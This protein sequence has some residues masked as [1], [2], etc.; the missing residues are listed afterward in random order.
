MSSR[1]ASSP[2]DGIRNPP[3]SPA[4]LKIG[5]VAG[6]SS[7]DL[8]GAGLIRSLRTL[9]PDAEFAGMAG[10]RMKAEG[11]V[12]WANYDRLAVMGFGEVLG[13]L[14]ELIRLRR[15]LRDRFGDWQPDV[16]VG[17]DSPD[18]NLGL[19]IML[20]GTGIPTVH[21]V[22]PS[23]WA[24]RPRRVKKIG[25]A[26]N[27]VLCL[28]PFETAPYEAAGI[29]VRF[30][31]HPLA[32]HFPPK[33]D[34]SAARLDLGLEEYHQ[35][36]ALMPGSRATELRALTDDFLLA[37][38]WLA[39][40]RRELIFL[41]PMANPDLAELFETRLREL[42]VD[43]DIRVI[44]GRSHDA[45]AAANVVLL[46]SGTATLEAAL[47]KRPMVVAYRVSQVSRFILKTFRLLKVNQFALP[48]LLAG[49]NLVPEIMQDDITPE[50]LGHAV[51]EFLDNPLL[52]ERLVESFDEI[53]AGLRQQADHQAAEAVFELLA[54]GDR[55]KRS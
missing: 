52:G 2:L 35:V 22:S 30:V 49:E 41:A 6:E 14:G 25:R 19:E 34:R 38:D 32:D 37:A 44:A 23:L 28:L 8:L 1:A 13:R 36:V 45:I 43:A 31:G 7:G 55:E 47:I 21:Y 33:S 46:A 4:P 48:N 24:W 11:C 15:D 16:F 40:H 10:P 54:S 51:L 20:R 9:S 27:L 42:A 3:E 26:A 39:G 50:R 18:F 29:P 53:H 12:S 5:L 17:I